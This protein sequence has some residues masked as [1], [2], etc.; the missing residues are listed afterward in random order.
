VRSLAWRLRGERLLFRTHKPYYQQP[1]LGVGRIVD[2][3]GRFYRITRRVEEPPVRLDRGG[4]IPQWQI[5][6]R[7]VSE[8]ELRAQESLGRGAGDREAAGDAED[9]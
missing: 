2:H 3:E 9:E 1:G 6:G 8:A 7:P 4:S 5:W